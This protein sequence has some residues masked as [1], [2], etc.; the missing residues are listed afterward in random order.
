MLTTRILI[1][2]FAG[3]CLL[4]FAVPTCAQSAYV[5]FEGE[6]SVWH[7]GF[8]RYDFMMDGS[9]MAI[10][11]FKP[12]ENEHFGIGGP[13]NG[14]RRC[15]VICP[16]QAAP[17]NPWSWR[18]CYW[19][20]Q[21]QTEIALLKRGF[22]V[23]YISA[24]SSLKPD[25]YWD[26][27]YAYLTE[28]HGL[29]KKPVFVG[30]SRG[31]EYSFM[32]ATTHPD[33]V[34]AIYSDNPGGNDENFR[35][36]PDLAR[37][38]VPVLL[39]CGT[40]DPI[41]LKF[42]TTIENIYQQFGGRISMMLKDGAGHHPH[43]LNDPTPIADFL[44][45]SFQEKAPIP[46]DYI[47]GHRFNR[48]AYY[49]LDSAYDKFP[50]DGYYITRRGPAF[51]ESYDRYELWLGFEVPVTIIAPKKEAARRPWVFRSGF[52]DRDAKVDQA[53]LAKGF[54]IVVG[55]VG[56]NSDGPNH[57]DWDKLYAHLTEHGFSKKPVI[58][59]AGGAAGA[60]YAWA[61]DNPDKVSCI[62]A[63][64]PILHTAGVKTQPLDNLSP[65]AR[66]GVA[67]LHVCGSLDPALDEQTRVA[68]KRYKE[69][70]G[71]ITVII[72]PGE[73]HY[74]TAPRDTRPVIDFI[75]SHQ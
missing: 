37:N 68:E 65:L 8:E 26:A 13:P 47:A 62:Y 72:K 28:K 56:Y 54:H 64:N 48:Y 18:G 27:W 53:L 61:I 38:D 45:Q 40:I 5:P 12:P 35:R 22:H 25:K 29:S 34:S 50:Q 36:L 9:T 11:P 46:P 66:A 3:L 30:M 10:S 20:H 63:E 1:H 75:M 17:G 15:V 16:K 32:W 42:A 55:P 24:D 23:A 14:G 59:G 21:P 43:S 57:T 52:V 39:V 71:S 60:V 33:K 6:K 58:E 7:D 49:S 4:A 67:L 2:L 69:L 70:N 73:G 19:D 44:V 51:T 31:G 41:L 74:P